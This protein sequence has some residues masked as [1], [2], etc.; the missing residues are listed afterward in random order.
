MDEQTDATQYA[1]ERASE[2]FDKLNDLH[3]QKGKAHAGWSVNDDMKLL[4][5]HW[6]V[7]VSDPK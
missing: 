7:T 3:M 4:L 2:L 1:K 6:A 5:Q